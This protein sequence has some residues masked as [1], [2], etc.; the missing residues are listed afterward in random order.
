M[1]E[2]TKKTDAGIEKDEEVDTPASEKAEEKKKE[3]RKGDFFKKEPVRL[4]GILLAI[5][6]TVAL[7]LGAVNGVTKDKV[8]E[9]KILSVSQA[10]EELYPGAEFSK[11]TADNK[12][13]R[14]IGAYEAKK[15][16]E[17]LGYCVKAETAGFGGKIEM[18]VAVNAEGDVK[19]VKILGHSETPGLGANAC[20]KGF[21]S[22]FKGKSG[23]FKI[24]KNGEP[25]GM[26][27]V[28]VSGATI[29]SN[30]VADGVRAAMDFV[31]GLQ[32]QG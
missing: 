5:T 11:I 32:L 23:S 31:E 7:M 9:N 29:T 14:I 22:Q 1:T 24:V 2:E 10:M 6:F 16:L 12:D 30:A 4:T 17:T 20:E 8:A 26:D 15:S 25:G 3:G 13:A 28:A 21:L 19:G 27:I 18:I